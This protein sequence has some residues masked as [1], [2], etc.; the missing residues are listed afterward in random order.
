MSARIKE[1]WY[2]APGLA[3]DQGDERYTTLTS[4][5]V[6]RVLWHF[7]GNTLPPC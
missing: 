4:I 7:F 6:N 1:V 5:F 3:P 2:L